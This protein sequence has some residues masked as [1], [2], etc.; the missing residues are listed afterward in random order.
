[1]R[2]REGSGTA[3]PAAQTHGGQAA[4]SP[5]QSPSSPLPA[6]PHDASKQTHRLLRCEPHAEKL[7]L[8]EPPGSPP[9]SSG[10]LGSSSPP[11]G[12]PSEAQG[13]GLVWSNQSSLRLTGPWR[14][15]RMLLRGLQDPASFPGRS[16]WACSISSQGIS[17]PRDAPS[18]SCHLGS[19]VNSPWKGLTPSTPVTSQ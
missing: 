14:R 18:P 9:P 4:A 19:G 8:S 1:M 2:D 16:S 5:D 17:G 7:Y 13:S 6:S 15:E 3:L 12:P 11:P 10:Q